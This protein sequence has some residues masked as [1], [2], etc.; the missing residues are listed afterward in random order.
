MIEAVVQRGGHFFGK[1]LPCPFL[2]GIVEME[3]WGSHFTEYWI[4]IYMDVLL[5][6]TEWDREPTR[7]GS[8]LG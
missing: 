6:K 7:T 1:V 3:G 4:V 2:E 5:C 8:L